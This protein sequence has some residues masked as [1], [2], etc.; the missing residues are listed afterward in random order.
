MACV[1]DVPR[2]VIEF[3]ESGRELGR[4]SDGNLAGPLE[5][6][7]TT[8][9]LA[10]Y[11]PRE[12]RLILDVGGGPGT[13]AAWLQERGHTVRL[14]DPVD[15]HV[16][17]ARGLGI[18]AHLGEAGQLPEPDATADAVLLM[19]PL[20]HLVDEA[21]RLRALHEARRVLRPGGVLIATAISRFATLLDQLVRLDRAHEPDELERLRAITRSGVL[22]AREGGVFTTAFMH[23]PR[24]LRDEVTAAGFANVTVVCVEGPGYLVPNFDERWSDPA[25]R[26]A[27]IEAARLVEDDPEMIGLGSHLLAIAG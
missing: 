11:V 13:Y 23:L 14:Y 24:Q 6:A 25:R 19:G 22:P 4:L 18:D 5:Y 16:E 17:H 7:R 12:A 21:D 15:R 26:A 2:E 3:Y 8:E 10:R 1:S 27:L 20:Y 9:L